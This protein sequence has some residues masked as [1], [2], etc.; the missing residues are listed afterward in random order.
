[1]TELEFP[2]DDFDENDILN[3]ESNNIRNSIIEQKFDND[4]YG[5]INNYMPKGCHFFNNNV[6]IVLARMLFPDRKWK[7][8]SSEYHTSVFTTD[9]KYCFDF[10]YFCLDD[11]LDDYIL[12]KPRSSTDHSLGAHVAYDAVFNPNYIEN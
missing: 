7:V 12:E 1:M 6:G 4:E 9:F 8:Y 3:E 5:L 11:R 2:K 10:I